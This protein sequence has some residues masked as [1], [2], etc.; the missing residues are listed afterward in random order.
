MGRAQGPLNAIE[1]AAVTSQRVIQYMNVTKMAYVA[2]GRETREFLQTNDF[3]VYI[4]DEM[5]LSV[6]QRDLWEGRLR[7]ILVA[8][9]LTAILVGVSI[10][11]RIR[12]SKTAT[13]KGPRATG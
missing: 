8:T 10:H 2:S 9:A 1:A 5:I 13:L 6:P 12:R 11:V 3:Y 4:R 7:W